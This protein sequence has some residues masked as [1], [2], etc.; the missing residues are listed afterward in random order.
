MS[1]IFGVI[2]AAF[3]TFCIAF[4]AHVAKSLRIKYIPAYLQYSPVIALSLQVAI[5]VISIMA[6]DDIFLFMLINVGCIAAT[7]A[8]L[9]VCRIKIDKLIDEHYKK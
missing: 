5:S 1:F 6:V 9:R 4:A 2:V 7:I 8:V 3:G